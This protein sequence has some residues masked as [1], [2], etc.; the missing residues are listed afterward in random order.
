MAGK[1]KTLALSL[2]G[3]VKN[4]K[5]ESTPA[6]GDYDP[7]KAEK[8]IQYCSPKYSFGVKTQ[9]D[10]TIATPVLNYARMETW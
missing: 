3:R 8:I 6:P 2:H 9:M 4:E 5:I 7:Q 10:K 1:D